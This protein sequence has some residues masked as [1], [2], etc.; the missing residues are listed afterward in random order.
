MMGGRG[1]SSGISNAKPISPL[2]ARVMYNAA[3][4]SNS[5]SDTAPEKRDKA[6]EKAIS[7]NNGKLIDSLKTEK[8]A[9][10]V[11]DYLNDRLNENRRKIVNLGSAEKLQSNP[12]L[13][14]E[15]KNITSLLNKAREKVSSLRDTSD[16]GIKNP[17][18]KNTTT[19]Y[20]RA[21]KRRMKKFDSWFG[22]R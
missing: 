9:R 1:G 21:R 19:T 2:M 11:A 16:F 12:K 3:K 20:D 6:I 7:S 13:Y 22:R 10:R 5:L 15:N 4:K 17:E 8:E 14:N 18:V